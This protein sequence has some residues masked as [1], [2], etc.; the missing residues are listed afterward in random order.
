MTTVLVTTPA[1]ISVTVDEEAATVI[2]EVPATVQV[3]PTGPAGADGADGATGPAGATGATGP[4]GATGATG[5]TGAQGPTGPTGATGPGV[6]VGGTTGQVL[7][8][9]NATNY[10]TEWVDAATGG[11]AVDSVNGETGVVSLSAADVGAEASGAVATHSADTTAVH[12][13]ADTSTL[14]RAGGTDVALAD[15]GTGASLTDPGADRIMFW[16]DS[17]GA[18]AFLTAGTNLTITDTTIDAAGGGGDTVITTGGDLIYGSAGA[19]NVDHAL[20]GTATA[21]SNFGGG[22]DISFLND[23]NEGTRWSSS[24]FKT[25]GDWVQITFTEAKLI[26]SY[27]INQ[28]PDVAYVAATWKLQKSA[29]NSTWVD[30]DTQSIGSYDSGTLSITPTSSQYWRCT[31]TTTG[32]VQWTMYSFNLYGNVGAAPARLSVGDELDVLTVAS[33]LP[34]WVAPNVPTTTAAQASRPAAATNG[35]LFLPTNGY[36]VQRDTGAAW[37]HWGPLFPFTA[38]PSSGWS[39]V[40]QGTATIDTTGGPIAL[41]SVATSGDDIRAYVRTAPSTPYVITAHLRHNLTATAAAYCGLCWRQSSDGKLVTFQMQRETQMRV[42]RWT[43][44]TTYG[45]AVDLDEV[46]P[47]WSVEWFRISDDGTDRKVWISADGQHWVLLHSIGRTT[48]LTADQVG[49]AVNSGSTTRDLTLT[50][51]SWAAT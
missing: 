12:G 26:H 6:P 46:P 38:P 2:Q 17:A 50:L 32:G 27:R 29:D 42:I 31:C 14:Y 30:V 41:T 15:G 51:L 20:S 21:W 13:I 33:G 16:D 28:Y 22:F 34:A 1:A 40:N 47:S 18:V 5:A 25:S 45:G 11:G 3:G 43:N 9:K 48:F 4:A 39:W 10:N 8:K 7:A 37:A 49:I 44:P 19:S 23:G 35:N 36:T 24:A